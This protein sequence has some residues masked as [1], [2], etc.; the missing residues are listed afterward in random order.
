MKLGYCQPFGLVL[1]EEIQD[2]R[3]LSELS[4]NTHITKHLFWLLLVTSLL[5]LT[6]QV[7]SEYKSPYCTMHP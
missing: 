4:T 3:K 5:I 6:L 1:D 7:S 2:W